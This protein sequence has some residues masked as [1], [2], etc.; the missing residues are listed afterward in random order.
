MALVNHRDPYV[1]GAALAAFTAQRLGVRDVRVVSAQHP[2]VGYTS[3]TVIVE[4]GW[5]SETDSA[6]ERINDFVVRLAPPAAATFRDYDLYQQTIAQHA[7]ADAGVPVASPKLVTDEQWLGC[8]F[9]VMPRIQGR[10]VGE[11]AAFDPWLLSLTETQRAT[12]HTNY[13]GAV[14]SIHRSDLALAAGVPTRDNHAELDFWSDYLDWSSAGSPVATLTEALM[15][16]RSHC[17][18]VEGEPVLLWGDVR[19]GNVIFSDDLSI[20]AILDWDMTSI[21]APEHDIAWLTTL[22]STTRLL[23]GRD[24]AGFPDRA[25]IVARY[26]S[27]SGRALQHFE[28]YETLAMVRS[29]AIMTRISYLHRDAGFR[30]PMPIDD[31]P[32]L[33]LIAKRIN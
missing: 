26:E 25:A 2:S 14:A 33:D 6:H 15:W 31:N 1:I 7:A 10:I 11:V 8:P 32:L 20:L 23:L 19:L 30:L 3:E 22:E 9:V 18:E 16:C 5:S 24:L 29:T 21:G 17:P 28:W 13:V 27:V 12:V 4:L